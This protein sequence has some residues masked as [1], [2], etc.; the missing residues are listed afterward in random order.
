MK[1]DLLK[2]DKM[3][4]IQL[5]LGHVLSAY[6]GPRALLR[7]PEATPVTEARTPASMVKKG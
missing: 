3:K 2:M 6:H 5:F 4:D 7:V 1:I